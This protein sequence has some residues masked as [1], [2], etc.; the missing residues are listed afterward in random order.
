MEALSAASGLNSAI[1]IHDDE[2]ILYLRT[3]DHLSLRLAARAGDRAPLHCTAAGKIFLAHMSDR[4]RADLLETLN[5]QKFTEYTKTSAAALEAE[6]PA[7]RDRGYAMAIREE[8]LH[9]IGMSA[10]IRDAQGDVTA[11]LSAWT[12][13]DHATPA[14]VEASA[15]HLLEAAA[16]ISAL[17]GWDPASQS[18]T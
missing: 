4:R 14:K 13:T 18:P 15:E 17:G 16:D 1:S 12:I 2:F 5:L 3:S 7:V 11:A 8:Y 9:V 6:M 10:P